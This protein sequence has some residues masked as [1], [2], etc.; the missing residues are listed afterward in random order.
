[1]SFRACPDCYIVATIQQAIDLIKNEQKNRYIEIKPIKQ[2]L[3]ISVIRRKL[4]P[5]DIKKKL[6]TIYKYLDKI[7]SKSKDSLIK[8]E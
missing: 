5:A 6:T 7:Y 3:N 4:I 1:L 8:R 2:A